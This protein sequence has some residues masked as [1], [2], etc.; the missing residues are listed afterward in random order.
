[1]IS[2]AN[3]LAFWRAWEAAH[4]EGEC[5]APMCAEWKRVLREWECVGSPRPIRL[6]ID[7]ACNYPLLE[8]VQACPN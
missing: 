4:K 7:N 2:L 8:W 6:F 1:M 5:D 3:R